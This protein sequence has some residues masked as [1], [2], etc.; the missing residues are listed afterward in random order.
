MGTSIVYVGAKESKKFMGMNFLRLVPVDVPNAIAVQ[1]LSEPTVFHPAGAP[2]PQEVLS[3]RDQLPDALIAEGIQRKKD[4][5][6]VLM[7]AEML[8]DDTK[9]D[10]KKRDASI[11]NAQAEIDY[12]DSLI[13]QGRDLRKR[14]AAEKE[15]YEKQL[16]EA[17]KA[18]AEK[19]AK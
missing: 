9:S 16:A 6:R 10:K 8:P 14:L 17:E 5:N 2:I 19:V 12:A 15:A 13:E 18:K 11:K 3:Q 1:A 7:E 4:Y